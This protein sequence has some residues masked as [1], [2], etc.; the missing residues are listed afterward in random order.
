[1]IKHNSSSSVISPFNPMVALDPKIRNRVN[2]EFINPILESFFSDKGG[3]DK[4]EELD[5]DLLKTEREFNNELNFVKAYVYKE[6]MKGIIKDANGQVMYKCRYLISFDA[7]LTGYGASSRKYPQCGNHIMYGVIRL[8]DIPILYYIYIDLQSLI[9]FI[10]TIDI[11]AEAVQLSKPAETPERR[12]NRLIDSLIAQQYRLVV[13]LPIERR[14]PEELEL[15]RLVALSKIPLQG[16]MGSLRVNLSWNTTD[17]L[18][19]HISNGDGNLINY[20]HKILEYNGSIGKLDVDA[21]AG[22]TLVSNPQ[23][24]I[25]WDIVPNGIHTVS[26]NLYCNREPKSRVP[27]TLFIDNGDESRVYNSYVEAGGTDQRREVV[28]FQLLGGMLVFK[29]LIT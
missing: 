28:E 14:E 13:S 3:I 21:N 9:R 16:E 11:V 29:D 12:R 20:Q 25:T 18:D 19:L 15:E 17:D 26:V 6:L 4:Y 1:M 8:G 10:K 7:D 2:S 27:F 23:E 22:G 5:S 24:N